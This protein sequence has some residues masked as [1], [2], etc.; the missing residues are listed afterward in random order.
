[1][2]FRQHIRVYGFPD[3][4]KVKIKDNRRG[5]L[6]IEGVGELDIF[7][8]EKADKLKSL[9]NKHKIP[10]KETPR[11][12]QDRIRYLCM[13]QGVHKSIRG[14][15]Y[16]GDILYT[17]ESDDER[18]LLDK[19]DAAIEELRAL[20]VKYEDVCKWVCESAP[21]LDT[22]KH[23]NRRQNKT[24]AV[25]DIAEETR[26]IKNTVADLQEKISDFDKRALRRAAIDDERVK[27]GIIY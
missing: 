25:K 18:N 3:A 15:K 13:D 21:K 17:V 26:K 22:Q 4:L 19:R 6:S 24:P 23:F 11:K 9:L 8:D 5:R 10:Y 16:K 27:K 2:K 20:K 7:S 14:R 12:Q 1:M